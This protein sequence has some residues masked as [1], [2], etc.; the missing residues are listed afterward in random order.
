MNIDGIF[1]LLIYGRLP[2]CLLKLGFGTGFEQHGLSAECQLD[3][4]C[5]AVV[6][7]D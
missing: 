7:S 2:V 1:R 6:G 3:G 4:V 5:C